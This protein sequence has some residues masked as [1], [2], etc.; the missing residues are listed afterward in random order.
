MGSQDLK[1]ERTATPPT[2]AGTRADLD[3]RLPPRARSGAP[4]QRTV[5]GLFDRWVLRGPD[6]ARRRGALLRRLLAI[7]DAISL[8]A[9]AAISV[10]LSDQLG[11][12]DLVWIL[13]FTPAWILVLKVHG[14]YD[15]DHR[16]IRHSTLD[17][18]STLIS[19]CAIGTLVLDGLLGLTPAGSLDASTAVLIGS[20][21]Y[22]LTLLS[23]SAVRASWHALTG[24]SVGLVVGSGRAAETIARR[25]AIHPEARLELVGY[26]EATSDPLGGNGHHAVNL[27]QLGK[28]ADLVE[29]SRKRSVERVVATEEDVSA[30]E[31]DYLIAECKRL[32]IALTLLP[33]HHGLFGP[34]IELNRLAELPVIDFRFADPPRS[35]LLLKRAIDIAVSGTLLLVSLPVLLLVSALIKLDSRGP[36]LFRQKRVGRDGAPFTML[37]FRTMVSDAEQRLGELVDL[38][39][40][41][42]PAF[43]IP[44]DPRVTRIGRPLRRLSID[45]MPQLFNVLRGDM[46]LVGPRPEEAAVVALYDERQRA[47]LGVK[48]GLT[49]PMQVYGRGDLS[50]EERL[51]LERDYLDNLSIAEDFAILLRTPRAVFRGSGAY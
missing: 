44:D 17:E 16:R 42:E 45:E 18:F 32:G 8:L 35:T 23:R 12:G 33:R 9:A 24:M 21:A 39:R 40:L 38:D 30:T 27:E 14:L 36:V 43:K 5:E 29:V 15:R 51:A 37:K 26:L 47:R 4:G 50:F 3:R 48:P 34:G 25:V 19:A 10:G 28:V 41:P 20:L 22:F 2:E 46:S 31:M 6:G 49:G 1:N 13:A 7:G 11:A